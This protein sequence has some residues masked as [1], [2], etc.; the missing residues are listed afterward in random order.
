MRKTLLVIIVPML[1]VLLTGC[2]S[3][4]YMAGSYLYKFQHG[5]EDAT[6]RIYVSMPK[7]IIH[8]NSA[9]NDV[10]GFMLMTE[11]EQDSVIASKTAI[12]DKVDD[13]VLIEQFSSYF[14]YTI[15]QSHI[16]VVVVDDVTSLPEADESHLV[17]DV[18]QIEL[19][20]MLTPQR[21]EFTT[22]KGYYYSYDYD[23]R[24]LDMNVWLR[25]D[26][27]DSAEVYFMG[28][29][30]D[31]NFHGTLVSLEEGSAKM[32]VDYERLDANHAYYLARQLGQKCGVLYIERLLTEHVRR[33]KGGNNYYF[34]WRPEGNYIDDFIFYEDGIKESFVPLK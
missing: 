24:S 32:K 18:A 30:V 33:M 11:R 6:E 21:S 34:Y 1:S 3:D 15:S 22:R 25:F 28:D 2:K 5:A 27:S 13:S 29:G 20:E 26:A 14:L 8:T 17:V 4:I 10:P 12:L 31:E 9:L 23:L 16:P 19:E 7:E